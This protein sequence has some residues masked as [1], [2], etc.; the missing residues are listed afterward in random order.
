MGTYGSQNGP[1]PFII[2]GDAVPHPLKGA[3]PAYGKHVEELEISGGIRKR[4]PQSYYWL[5]E[6]LRPLMF[7]RMN[8][9]H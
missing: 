6:V 1:L 9:W 8:Y 5:V 2:W 7:Q 4:S 3:P